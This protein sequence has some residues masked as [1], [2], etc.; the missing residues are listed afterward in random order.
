[1]YNLTL[2]LSLSLSLYIYI[3]IYI[4][5]KHKDY[6]RSQ[7]NWVGSIQWE[8]ENIGFNGW[9]TR[10]IGVGNLENGQENYR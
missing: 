9:F 10:L 4:Y 7:K 2:S 5:I 1:M 8:E 6:A 3:Y